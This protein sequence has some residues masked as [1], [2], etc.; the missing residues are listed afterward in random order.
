M[1]C[2]LN[3]LIR[4]KKLIEQPLKRHFST[5]QATTAL[6]VKET[7]SKEITVIEGE[8]V[9]SGWEGKILKTAE[10][11]NDACPI[12][13]LNVEIKYTDVLI[14]QQFLN[15]KGGLLPRRATG[16]CQKSQNE[17]QTAVHKAQRAGLMPQ[18]RPPPKEGRP[19]KFPVSNF[20]WKRFPAYYD[21]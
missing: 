2:R 10:L 17:L 12:C 21:D 4:I 8:K 3:S 13:R 18:F 7:V 15:D 19:R 11:K 9:D 6:R 5:T 20:K 16:V 14:L 1:A